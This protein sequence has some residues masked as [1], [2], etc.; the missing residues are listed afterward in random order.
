MSRCE[1]IALLI[2][3]QLGLPCR[4]L[5]AWSIGSCCDYGPSSPNH[6]ARNPDF[7]AEKKSAPGSMASRGLAA[8]KLGSEKSAQRL[9]ANFLITPAT[10]FRW[11]LRQ[12][13][14]DG[15]VLVLRGRHNFDHAS[16]ETAL[17]VSSRSAKPRPGCMIRKK[18]KH[19]ILQSVRTKTGLIHSASAAAA[20]ENW[21]AY[22]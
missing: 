11:I 3:Y 13:F 19:D 7:R 2:L 16:C 10:I 17:I 18:T 14:Q 15:S 6:T 8:F 9:L 22:Q 12:S 1:K 21:L 5:W 4:S 20:A